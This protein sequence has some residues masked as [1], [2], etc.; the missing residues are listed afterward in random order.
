MARQGRWLEN[1]ATS[2]QFQNT[3]HKLQQQTGSRPACTFPGFPSTVTASEATGPPFPRH[4][5]T[6]GPQSFGVPPQG[7]LFANRELTISTAS[8]P[9]RK[10]NQLT[11]T[12]LKH[13]ARAPRRA[14]SATVTLLQP[15]APKQSLSPAGGRGSACL[16]ASVWCDPPPPRLL[17]CRKQVTDRQ[18]AGARQKPVHSRTA[19]P[20]PS[21]TRGHDWLLRAPPPP[22]PAPTPLL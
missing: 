7:S 20:Q 15:T 2:W 9:P 16:S 14:D 6:C 4:G 3:C 10:G 21:H 5:C 8:N 13:E 18:E 17:M 19:A 1:S 22:G 11:S 12:P